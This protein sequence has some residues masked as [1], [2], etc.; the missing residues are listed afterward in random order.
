VPYTW[1]GFSTATTPF[2]RGKPPLQL[3]DEVDELVKQSG[4]TLLELY[5]DVGT[6]VAYA[7]IKDLG[8]SV[9]TKRVSRELGGVKY[10]KLLDAEQAQGAIQSAAP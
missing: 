9:D 8:G 1:L 3:R 6:E 4:G 5:F 2:V 7:L 10:T